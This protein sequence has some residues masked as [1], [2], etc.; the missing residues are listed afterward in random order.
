MIVFDS[1]KL[2]LI[3]GLLLITTFAVLGASSKETAVVRDLSVNSNGDSVEVKIAANERVQYTYFELTKPRRLVVDFHG[4]QNDIGFK[5]KSIDAAGVQRVRTS[6]FT[7]KDRKG[8]RV[9]FDLAE[10]VPYKV[11]R[12]GVG[13]VHVLF[14]NQSVAPPAAPAAGAAAPAV[15]NES[16]QTV[17]LSLTASV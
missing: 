5:E 8:T 4:F 1:R 10:N 6:Y 7:E 17:P 16:Q 3:G 9:V 2:L 12:D 15:A 11:N 14:G 13:S